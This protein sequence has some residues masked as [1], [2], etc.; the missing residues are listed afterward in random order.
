MNTGRT[1]F[2]KGNTGKPKG[3]ANKGTQFKNWLFDMFFKHEDN[4]EK[5]VEGMLSDE[6]KVRWYLELLAGLAPKEVE[7]KGSEGNSQIVYVINNG[8][9]KGREGNR[10]NLLPAHKSAEDK[11]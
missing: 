4:I 5:V 7:N 2:K 6:R 11:V 10:V 8:N 1:R 9:T 3:T